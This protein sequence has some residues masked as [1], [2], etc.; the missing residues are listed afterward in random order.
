MSEATRFGLCL[1]LVLKHEGGYSEHPAD[2]GGATLNGVTQANYDRWRA[3]QGKPLQHVRH[4]TPDERDAIYLRDYWQ[5]GKCNQ[6][7]APLD[8][9]H[10]DG[11]VNHGIKQAAKFLQ[12][13][14]GVDDDGDIGPQTL[15]AVRQDDAAGRI[16]DICANILD[17][18][19][20]FYRRIVERNPSQ[21]VFINGWMNRINDVREKVLA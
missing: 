18:R 12:R 5:A 1:A 2:K 16:D 13:A 4:M 20:A 19:A 3:R 7:P 9:V 15:A 11:S 6:M 8:Y 17:Q 14:L 10:F 21:Q